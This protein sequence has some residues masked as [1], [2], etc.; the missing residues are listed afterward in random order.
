MHEQKLVTARRLKAA[1]Q[2]VTVGTMTAMIVTFDT[3][4]DTAA[5]D[6]GYQESIYQR[7]IHVKNSCCYFEKDIEKVIKCCQTMHQI[8]MKSFK[9]IAACS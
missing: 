1:L 5:R 8:A 2:Q 6:M 9:D 3:A 4:F 7:N